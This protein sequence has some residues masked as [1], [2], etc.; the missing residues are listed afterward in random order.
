MEEN[1]SASEERKDVRI[2]ENITLGADGKYRWV[3]SVNLFTNPIFLLL[4]WKIF[5]FIV[6]GIFA[7]TTVVDVID[8][9]G[10]SWD[11]MKG[12]LKVFGIIFGVMTALVLVGYLLYA[13]IMRGKYTVEFEMDEK[14]VNHRQI[15]SQAKKAK[16]VG[17]AA[18]VA[19]LLTGSYSTAAAGASSQ[20][21][22]MYSEFSKT[23][24]VVSRPLFRVIKIKGLLSNNQVY[25]TKEDFGF[26]KNYIIEHCPNLK[27]ANKKK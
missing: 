8:W 3:Y 6:L 15:E 10:F 12:Q 17:E 7:F 27:G 19:G 9:G 4:V 16:K 5:F 13:A 22:E 26:V 1:N 14:G 24:R 11:L 18:M 20:R 25:A 21:T 23:R 2:S